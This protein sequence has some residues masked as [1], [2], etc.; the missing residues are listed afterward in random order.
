MKS[1]RFISQA[2]IIA[3][4]YVVFT[5][6]FLPISFGAIQ[7]RI[8][9]ALCLL[10]VLMP[11]A[12][13]GVTLGCLISNILGSGLPPDII[14]G[15]LATFIGAVITYRIS[16]TFRNKIKIVLK[17]PSGVSA[18][19]LKGHKD[20]DNDISSVNLSPS[21][22]LRIGATI[23]PV[24]SNMIIV[25]LVLKYAYMLNDAYIFLVITVGIGEI[26]SVGIIG[27][28]LLSFLLRKNILKQLYKL[29]P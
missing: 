12:I 17:S 11:E 1:A 8:S 19:N 29:E 25:P 14:F 5:L 21:L 23:P 18:V 15:T 20:K 26:L 4:L 16:A 6:F 24:L 28:I 27:N 10:P 7:C 13:L 22:G 9:E 2:A 3:C